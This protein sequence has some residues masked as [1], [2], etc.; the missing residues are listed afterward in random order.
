M[1]KVLRAWDTEFV[2]GSGY[3][4]GVN[5][6]HPDTWVVAHAWAD[7]SSKG[8]MA[9]GQKVNMTKPV[10]QYYT[11]RPRDGWFAEV[12]A[13][14]DVLTGANIKIDIHV[15]TYKQPK[16][17]KAYREWINRGGRIWDV[18]QAE[19]ILEGHQEASMH[20]SLNEVAARYGGNPKHDQVSAMIKNGVPV[21]QID[22]HLLLEYLCGVY[23]DEVCD[24][25]DIG[26]T[27]L[28]AVGQ[29]KQAQLDKVLQWMKVENLAI[30]ATTEM[31]MNGIHVDWELGEAARQR[32][33]ERLE[34]AKKSLLEY[35]PGKTEENFSWGSWKDKSRILFGGTKEVEIPGY[36]NIHGESRERMYPPTEQAYT[37]ESYEVCQYDENWQPIL[38]K[39][40]KL[41]GEAKT[42][43]LKGI[44]PS[45]PKT[46]KTV[47]LV[48][49][50]RRLDP[51]EGTEASEEGFWSTSA[52]NMEHLP[53]GDPVVD[54]VKAVT[55][56]SKD[57]ST[58]YYKLDKDGNKVG[59]VFEGTMPDGLVHP[60]FGHNGTISG[61]LNSKSPNFQNQSAVGEIKTCF[62]SRYP[63]G[64]II[65]GDATS[66]ENYVMLWLS[67]CQ[68]YYTLIK[69]GLDIHSYVAMSGDKEASLALKA[70]VDAGDKEAKQIRQNAKGVNFS[71]GYGGGVKSIAYKNQIPEDAVKEMMEGNRKAFSEYWAFQDSVYQQ[72]TK[73]IVLTGELRRHPLDPRKLYRVGYGVWKA[74]HGIH[75]RYPLTPTPSFV[76]ERS[77]ATESISPTQAKNLHV[78]GTGASYMKAVMAVFIL[79]YMRRPDLE[80]AKAIAT[81][82]DAFY[83]DAPGPLVE[84]AAD[85]IQACLQ[86]GNSVLTM[87]GVDVRIPVPA[88][89]TYGPC[90][91]EMPG[92]HRVDS[93]SGGVVNFVS[94]INRDILP[95]V[96]K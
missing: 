38:N 35:I 12:L 34:A 71:M 69:E 8:F 53:D 17:Y 9:G 45:K 66:L 31:E 30:Q 60:G 92:D 52:D 14:C 64:K 32:S 88:V 75:W 22:K 18:L 54:L 80:E 55:T 16:N 93:K 23:T 62:T 96:F 51:P 47:R 29:I 7:Y 28:A 50:P 90:W 19:Y 56:W 25:G 73:S 4:R 1:A 3:L 11:H 5:A 41:K 85:L 57:I 81:V 77:G 67:G 13:G 44:N 83:M 33:V 86:E 24:H 87:A 40:G 21:N 59:G 20:L 15:A 39:S 61:R 94:F 58:S 78:Q 91:K 63:D 76:L 42:K 48:E 68:G 27:L 72:A 37:T 74:P 70:R 36:L 46:K 89:T 79:A 49:F 2:V 26:N 6:F 65:Q 82:H 43:K 84:T 10:Y 95:E